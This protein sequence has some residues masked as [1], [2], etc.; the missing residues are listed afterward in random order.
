MEIIEIY[1]SQLKAVTEFLLEKEIIFHPTIS[2]NGCPDFTGRFGRKNLL[3]IDR[4]IMTKIVEF[5]RSGKLNDAHI[6]KLIGALILWAEFNDVS[7]TCGLALNEYASNK[8]ANEKASFENNIFLEMFDQYSPRVWLDVFEN[9]ITEI[10]PIQITD[11]TYYEFEFENEHYLMHLSEIIFLY[12]LF[13]RNDIEP[14]E[15]VVEFLSWIDDHLLF[16]AYSVTYAC[17]LFSNKVKQPKISLSDTFERKMKIC[18]NQAWDL[19]YLSTWSTI[20]SKEKNTNT[21][22]LFAT[23]DIDLKKMFINTHDTSNNLFIR[24]F[25]ETN[26]S[27][28]QSCYEEIHSNRQKPKMNNKIIHEILDEQKKEMATCM[29]R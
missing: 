1:K 27:K 7:I 2:P 4:N 5:C 28:I 11:N 18:S 13:L 20:Y 9:K 23:M 21:N 12:R 10:P 17:M 6:R 19:S 25:G 29:S 16:C 24:F 8:G 26:G 14:Y 22:H 15:K 3:I